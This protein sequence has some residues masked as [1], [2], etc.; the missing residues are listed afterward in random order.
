MGVSVR[1]SS[2]Y[3]RHKPPSVARLRRLIHIDNLTAQMPVIELVEGKRKCVR[4]WT[5][6]DPEMVCGTHT[7]VFF[8]GLVIT[9]TVYPSGRVVETVNRQA[10]KRSERVGTYSTAKTR[11]VSSNADA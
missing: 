4:I 6:Y 8:T 7:D 3:I 11:V 1:M 10:D 9:A 5:A 2:R